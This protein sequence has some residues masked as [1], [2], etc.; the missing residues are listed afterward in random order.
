MD[1]PIVITGSDPDRQIT[2]TR[3][4]DAPRE[5]VFK[6][7]TDADHLSRWWGPNGF[8]NTFHEFDPHPG[9]KW[10]FIMHGPDK[11]DYPNESIF[12]KI[13][14]PAFIAFAH[15]SPPRFQLQGIFEVAPG[16]K[17]KLVFKQ[18]FSTTEECRKIRPFI[19]DKNEE[20]LDRLEDELR[21]M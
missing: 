16:N 10:R 19:G 18:I 2:A 17:T 8:T 7:W 3:I 6:A 21:K 11:K 12:I 1:I 5:K 20:N 9:G 14:P 15:I 13:D 4:I